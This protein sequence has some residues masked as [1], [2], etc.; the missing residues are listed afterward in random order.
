MKIRCLYLLSYRSRLIFSQRRQRL[1]PMAIQDSV[2]IVYI[3]AVA[4]DVYL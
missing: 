1:I 4:S 3:L 2:L